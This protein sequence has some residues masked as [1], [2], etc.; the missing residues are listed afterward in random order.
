MDQSEI[1]KKVTEFE[2]FRESF[3]GKPVVFTDAYGRNH[4]GLITRVWAFNGE[5]HDNPWS[6]N[7]VVVSDNED[8][9]DQYGRQ[10]KRHTSVVRKD[11]QGAH[12]MYFELV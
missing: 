12:G 3:T 11:C 10:I 1:D 2:A 5:N 7:L 4:N 8:E 9:N 6:L